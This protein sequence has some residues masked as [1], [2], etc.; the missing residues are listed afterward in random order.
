MK[1]ATDSLPEG[2]FDAHLHLQ[3]PSLQ[4]ALIRE[5]ERERD[6]E[7][8]RALPRLR[9]SRSGPGPDP[10]PGFWEP[11]I[12]PIAAQ[13]V[14]GTH[15][16]D[17]AAVRALEQRGGTGL[18]RAYGVHPWRVGDLPD[19][20]ER[21]L[22]EYLDSG[23]ASIGEIGLDHW[24]EPRDEQRQMDVFERQLQLAHETGLAPTIH[25]LRAWGLLID[26]LRAGPAL[27][28]GFLVHGFGGSREVL[29][30]L[31]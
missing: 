21:Q 11:F 18:L 9:S 20:W 10:G 16:D 14:N 2:F 13:V 12:P 25:C 6:R 4:K 17:W 26:I 1:P 29:F 27:P 31:L 30:Q 28:H 7:R 23:A 8:E 24:K 3:D 22:R 15:P 19:D 5:R